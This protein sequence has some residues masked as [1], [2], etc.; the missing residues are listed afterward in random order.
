M[1][2]QSGKGRTF[3]L[4][5]SAVLSLA[6]CVYWLCCQRVR[7]SCAPGT[8]SHKPAWRAKTRFCTSW[9]MQQLARGHCWVLRQVKVAEHVLTSHKVAIKILNRKKIKQMDMEEKGAA[10]SH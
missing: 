2:L 3:L 4:C 1:D 5:L 8:T 9:R 7:K 10:P 6:V